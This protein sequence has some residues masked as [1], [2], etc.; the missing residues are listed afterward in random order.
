MATFLL[1]GFQS[2]ST[3]KTPPQALPQPA[4]SAVKQGALTG[5]LK[6]KPATLKKALNYI[7]R[8][9]P[10]PAGGGTPT[11]WTE[12]TLT[13][14]KS[15]VISGLTPGTIYTFQIRALGRLG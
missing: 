2:A 1:S 10:V 6:V 15:V 5:Q 13:S 3:V 14:S 4:I 7:L 8:Y 11:T 9:T 12:Q